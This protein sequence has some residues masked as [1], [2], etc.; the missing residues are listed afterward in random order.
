MSEARKV[1]L[2]TLCRLG[3]ILLALAACAALWAP[4]SPALL[5]PRVEPCSEGQLGPVRSARILPPAQQRA[6]QRSGSHLHEASLAA[7]SCSMSPANMLTGRLRDCTSAY[8]KASRSNYSGKLRAAIAQ[9][10][11]KA[12]ILPGKEDRVVCGL[13]LW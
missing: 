2:P 5:Q 13:A 3:S 7:N 12:V 4:S 9:T 8:R 1:A 11:N 10:A 6:V